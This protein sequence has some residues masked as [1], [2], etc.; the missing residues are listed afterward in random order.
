MN[1][2]MENNCMLISIFFKKVLCNEALEQSKLRLQKVIKLYVTY[3]TD[4][5]K[6]INK[7]SSDL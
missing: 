6:A 2:E 4:S 5:K 1:Q 3:C 7:S